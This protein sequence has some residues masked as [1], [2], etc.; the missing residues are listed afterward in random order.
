MCNDSSQLI[1]RVSIMAVTAAMLGDVMPYQ[2]VVGLEGCRLLRQI[3]D[4]PYWTAKFRQELRRYVEGIVGFDEVVSK[5][6]S[7]SAGLLWRERSVTEL[8][9]GSGRGRKERVCSGYM[10]DKRGGHESFTGVRGT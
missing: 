4:I 10:R 8:E 2:A 7:N 3:G 5:N 9:G 6:K 1:M